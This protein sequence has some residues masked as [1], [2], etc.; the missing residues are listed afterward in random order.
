METWYNQIYAVLIMVWSTFVVESWKRK[1]CYLADKW[2]M[3]DFF[4]PTLERPQFRAM[5]AIDEDLRGVMRK[6]QKSSYI[7]LL[8]IGI[9]VTCCFMAG[10]IWAAMA[11]RARYDEWAEAELAEGEKINMI[12]SL[13]PSVSLTLYITIFATIFKPVARW[14]TNFEDHQWID[15]HENSL[16]AKLMMFHFVNSYIANF[17]FAFWDRDFMLLAKNVATIMVFSQIFANAVEFLQDR[18]LTSRNIKKVVDHFA[19]N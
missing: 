3:R 13:I 10:A 6:P 19:T 9:P 16:I 11:T 14:L 5:L 1:E 18:F 12:A 4:D 8:C 7:R 17:I 2:L 15:S